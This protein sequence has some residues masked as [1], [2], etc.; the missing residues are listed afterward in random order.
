VVLSTQT[1][2]ADRTLW[3]GPLPA[4]YHT[5][6]KTFAIEEVLLNNVSIDAAL[7]NTQSVMDRDF[8]QAF[9]NLS[10]AERLYPYANELR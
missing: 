4:E 9:R 5:N 1:K 6:I 2:I 8:G 10:F 3:P 7:A